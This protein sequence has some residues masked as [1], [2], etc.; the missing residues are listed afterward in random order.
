MSRLSA[1]HKAFVE[2]M[3]CCPGLYPNVP[4]SGRK[5]L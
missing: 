3:G 1:F 4:I 5:R 2:R